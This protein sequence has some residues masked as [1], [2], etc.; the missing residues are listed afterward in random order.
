[1]IEFYVT[2]GKLVVRNSEPLVVTEGETKPL[3]QAE[4]I[5]LDKPA[6]EYTSVSFMLNATIRNSQTTNDPVNDLTLREAYTH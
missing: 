6:P 4:F 1:M 3:S 2:K 5:L